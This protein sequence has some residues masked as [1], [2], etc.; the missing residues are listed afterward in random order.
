MGSGCWAP[1]GDPH[2]GFWTITGATFKPRTQ[3]SRLG[4]F[5]TKLSVRP[6]SLVATCGPRPISLRAHRRRPRTPSASPSSAPGRPCSQATTPAF[7]SSSLHPGRSRRSDPAPSS[8]RDRPTRARPRGARQLQLWLH[9]SKTP[10]PP[11]VSGAKPG[12]SAI[13]DGHQ[14]PD[15]RALEDRQM[16]RPLL[17]S[18]AVKI[19]LATPRRPTCT[20][21]NPGLLLVFP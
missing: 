16:R 14:G 1:R 17:T 8:R 12:A 21:A 9:F 2:W 13:F 18:L 15:T 5:A 3:R 4:R 10:M 19:C 6:S 20:A 7:S 11:R